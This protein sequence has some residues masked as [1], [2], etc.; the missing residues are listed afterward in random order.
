MRTLKSEN[1]L[2][3]NVGGK[4]S[5]YADLITPVPVLTEITPID[6]SK[7]PP[8]PEENNTKQT[9]ANKGLFINV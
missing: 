7:E 2:I 9:P 5:R 4:F 6:D 8:T 3:S 1:M